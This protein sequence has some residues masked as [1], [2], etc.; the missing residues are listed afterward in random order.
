M[1]WKDRP[2]HQDESGGVPPVVFSLPKLTPLTLG[3]IVACT[4]IFFAQVFTQKSGAPLTYWGALTFAD[5]RAFTQPWRWITYQ[6]LHG[7]V[8]HYLF[9]ML[10]V[11]FFLADLELLWGW[12]KAFAFYTAGG[13][14]AGVTFGLLILCLPP[15]YNGL[16]IIGAS[17][18]IFAA[19]G[20]VALLLPNRQL[21]L[22]FFPVPIRPAVALLGVFFFLTTV[23][24]RDFSNACHL[25]GLI[26]GFFAPYLGGPVLIRTRRKWDRQRVRRIAEAEIAEQETVDR[27][28]QKVHASGMNSLTRAER[29]ALKL[30]TEHQRQ[31][32]LEL[33]KVRGKGWR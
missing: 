13:I 32:D 31:R 1:G 26:F 27:I 4:V 6:Y 16:P 30:A 20:A 21:I 5:G 15:A 33:A 19:M 29:K 18:A 3:V 9:N 7:G 22:L 10:A 28:L 11:Y 17:G 12:K 24:E 14:V 2:Y 8:S 25:G 23:L